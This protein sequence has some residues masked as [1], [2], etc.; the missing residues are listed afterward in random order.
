MNPSIT[1]P[2][3]RLLSEQLVQELSA[4]RDALMQLSLY[5]R[6]WQF[7]VDQPARQMAQQE[8]EALLNPLRHKP[9]AP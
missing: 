7:E 8:A 3:R 5:L 6:D 4:M 1:P 9:P 2:D